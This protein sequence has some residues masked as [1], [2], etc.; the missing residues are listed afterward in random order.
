[1]SWLADR[2]IAVTG[3]A[4]VTLCDAPAGR[5]GTWGEDGCIQG[6]LEIMGIPYTGSGVLASALAASVA[7]TN[8]DIIP[9]IRQD[10]RA[11][12]AMSAAPASAGR[13]SFS[14]MPDPL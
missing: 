9:N 11:L 6:L 12:W 14:F 1:M 4:S 13:G 8:S 7:S 10:S 5:G 2:R 3:G